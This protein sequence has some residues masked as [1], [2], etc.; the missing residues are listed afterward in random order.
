MTHDL[1]VPSRYALAA[2]GITLVSVL[3]AVWIN[4]A[5]S[6]AQAA[7]AI[8]GRTVAQRWCASC[9]A[10]SSDQ[11]KASADAPSFSAIAESRRIPEIKGFLTQSHPSMPDM[12]LTTTEIADLIAYMQ[13]QGKPLDPMKPPVEKDNPPKEYR[14]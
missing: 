14:G 5:S 12:A 9:H 4:A 7:D 13:T 2:I 1:S 11:K 6:P 3:V 10:I 8:N